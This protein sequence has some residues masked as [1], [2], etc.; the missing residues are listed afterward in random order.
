MSLRVTTV[1]IYS[2]RDVAISL[3]LMRLLLRFVPRNDILGL[4][5][6][7]F[8]LGNTPLRFDPSVFIPLVSLRLTQ[9]ALLSSS[10][11]LSA[12]DLHAVLS[13]IKCGYHLYW[14]NKDGYGIAPPV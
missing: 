3:F 10:W 1:Y 4:Y 9:Y 11:F 5:E 12:I 14:S 13:I 2:G 6:P 7:E 8:D